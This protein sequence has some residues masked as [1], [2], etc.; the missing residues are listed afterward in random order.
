MIRPGHLAGAAI[1]AAVLL[2]ATRDRNLRVA[3]QRHECDLEGLAERVGVLD[4]MTPEH[5]V[6]AR[7]ISAAE[8]IAADRAMDTHAVRDYTPAERRTMNTLNTLFAD[9][10]VQW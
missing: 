8:Y 9:G 1:A 5:P 4:G 7:V 3:V 6:P 2:H 10:E